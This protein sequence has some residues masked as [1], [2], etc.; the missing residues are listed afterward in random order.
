MAPAAGAEAPMEG[1]SEKYS[2]VPTLKAVDIL[3]D[4]GWMPQTVQESGTRVAHRTGFQKHIIRF[5][6]PG[7]DMGEERVDMMLVNSHDRGC[8][9]QLLASIWRKI[10]SNGLMT[11]SDLAN[12]KHKHIGFNPDEFFLSANKIAEQAAD[13]AEQVDD[14]KQIELSPHERTILAGTAHEYV[15]GDN[16]LPPVAADKLLEERRY[17]DQGQDLWTTYNVIQEN[18]MKG[19]LRGLGTDKNGKL[20]RKRTR[21]VKSI[22]RDVKLN[23]ALWSMAEQMAELKAA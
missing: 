23:Q 1:A 7:L 3:R 4:A 9:F 14:M 17:D 18:L 8:S 2:F 19:G 5:A 6:M 10:C 21:A 11:S 16:K 13:I 22:D 15:W 20:R 12:F